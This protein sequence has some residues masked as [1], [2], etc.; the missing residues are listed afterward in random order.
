MVARA[1]L[2]VTLY[3]S[4]VSYLEL[5]LSADGSR[6]PP[7]PAEMS[8]QEVPNTSCQS[9]PCDVVDQKPTLQNLNLPVTDNKTC[10]SHTTKRFGL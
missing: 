6:T 7:V 9:G 1:R 8:K 2:N 4:F 10:V 5:C 3:V